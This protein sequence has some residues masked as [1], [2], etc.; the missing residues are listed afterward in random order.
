[1]ARPRAPLLFDVGL[2]ALGDASGDV[3]DVPVPS[4]AAGEELR[5]PR[6]SEYDKPPRRHTTYAAAVL[7][8]VVPEPCVI[9]NW[10]DCARMV[11]KSS[12]S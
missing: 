5:S 12:A 6:Y 11:F 10:L 1:M 3:S 2:S 7:E 8:A 4:V 9:V